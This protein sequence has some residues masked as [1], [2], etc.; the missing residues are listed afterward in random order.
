MKEYMI[1][2]KLNVPP[3]SK[4]RMEYLIN[5]PNTEVEEN[6]IFNIYR[7]KC[8]VCRKPSIVVHELIPR[9]LLP[10]S[11]R[12]WINRVILC[13]ACHH[14]AHAHGTIVERDFLVLC[15]NQRLG[16]YWNIWLTQ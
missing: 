7:G 3:V 16:E 6:E 11:W 10:N 12:R 4:E 14:D 2:R 9:S 13:N 5:N 15:R 8:I 1:S